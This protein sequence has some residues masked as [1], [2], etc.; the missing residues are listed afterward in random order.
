MGGKKFNRTFVLLQKVVLGDKIAGKMDFLT[1]CYSL[2]S[3]LD[4]S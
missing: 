2:L 4:V 3:C 1:F